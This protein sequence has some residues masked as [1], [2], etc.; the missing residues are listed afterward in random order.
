MNALKN[1]YVKNGQT[2]RVKGDT[3]VFS[4]LK[5]LCRTFFTPTFRK[6]RWSISP[7]LH[8]FLLAEANRKSPIAPSLDRISHCLK[9]SL[10]RT[11]IVFFFFSPSTLSKQKNCLFCSVCY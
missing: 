5:L 7:K 1:F 9:H 8:G 10:F 2:V 6:A 3:E 4:Y 11:I